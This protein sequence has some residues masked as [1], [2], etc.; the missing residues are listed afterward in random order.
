MFYVILW[1]LLQIVS[2]V[3]WLLN[4]MQDCS[5]YNMLG[6]WLA[7]HTHRPGYSLCKL[8]IFKVQLIQWAKIPDMCP[9]YTHFPHCVFHCWIFN[10]FI[11]KTKCDTFVWTTLLCG[12]KKSGLIF[13][14]RICQSGRMYNVLIILLLFMF[15]LQLQIDRNSRPLWI[16][17]PQLN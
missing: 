8:E 13:S 11:E 10:I 5:C 1:S 12:C 7:E 9:H 16:P 2:V 17:W 6:V 14:T 15:V 4:L 3:L